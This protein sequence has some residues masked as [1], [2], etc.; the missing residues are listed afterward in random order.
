MPIECVAGWLTGWHSG[1]M[2]RGYSRD[3]RERLL[4]AMASGLSA[5]EIARTTGVST[6]SLRRWKRKQAAGESL[7]PA[8]FPGGP[9]KIGDTDEPFLRA[10]V[11]AHPDATLAEHCAQWAATGHPPVSTATMSRA[12]TRLGLPLKKRA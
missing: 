12:L 10:Q 9:R 11:L 3:R 8:T 4:Q 6:S 2:A 7:E 1:G 5:V